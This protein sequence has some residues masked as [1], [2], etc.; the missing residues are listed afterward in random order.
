MDELS[1]AC[2]QPTALESVSVST[3]DDLAKSYDG[4]KPI[5]DFRLV[6]IR[7]MPLGFIEAR[8]KTSKLLASDKREKFNSL[9]EFVHEGRSFVSLPDYKITMNDSNLNI[10]RTE[11]TYRT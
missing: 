5:P 9:L 6:R 8:K 7:R 4:L 1:S 10:A 2:Q 3:E 11:L